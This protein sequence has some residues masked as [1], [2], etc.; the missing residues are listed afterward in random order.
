MSQQCREMS[1][2]VGG[3]LRRVGD[4]LCYVLHDRIADRHG[5]TRPGTLTV[6]WIAGRRD[7]REQVRSRCTFRL[8]ALVVV[9]DRCHR[10]VQSYSIRR[11]RL[12]WPTHAR[13][14]SLTRRMVPGSQRS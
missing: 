11:D 13:V 8:V 1:P 7:V 5:L 4:E 10:V 3:Q 14:N 2:R 12:H 9:C 6:G